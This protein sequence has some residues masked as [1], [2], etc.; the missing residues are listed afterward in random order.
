VNSVRSVRALTT[1][2]GGKSGQF[3][4]GREEKLPRKQGLKNL[5]G[6]AGGPES[7]FK[8][9]RKAPNEKK[10]KQRLSVGKDSGCNRKAKQTALSFIKRCHNEFKGGKIEE[11]AKREERKRLEAGFTMLFSGNWGRNPGKREKR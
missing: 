8:H 6:G 10:A 3:P 1:K 11:K 2:E 9:Q 4:Q 7:I 5:V